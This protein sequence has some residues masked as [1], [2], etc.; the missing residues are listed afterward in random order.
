MFS[1]QQRHMHTCYIVVS[2]S[3]NSQVV[4][5]VSMMDMSEVLQDL[6]RCIMHAYVRLPQSDQHNRIIST[7]CATCAPSHALTLL[8]HNNMIC[9]PAAHGNT[10]II[11]TDCANLDMLCS[12]TVDYSFCTTDTLKFTLRPTSAKVAERL[13]VYS[14]FLLCTSLQCALWRRL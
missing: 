10:P 11:G 13:V 2:V 12:L 7:V 9:R 1:P 4:F 6:P 5:A 3:L 8:R 14:R